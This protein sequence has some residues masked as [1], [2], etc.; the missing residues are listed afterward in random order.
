MTNSTPLH[1]TAKGKYNASADLIQ[2]NITTLM[3]DFF[4]T[5]YI[6]SNFLTKK[7]KAYTIQKNCTKYNIKPITI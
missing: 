2:S 6:F 3:T 5:K 1:A 7:F 4:A